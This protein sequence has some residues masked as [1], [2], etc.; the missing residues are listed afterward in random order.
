MLVV[1]IL[2]PFL[3]WLAQG[4]DSNACEANNPSVKGI[5]LIQVGFRNVRQSKIVFCPEFFQTECGFTDTQLADKST[6]EDLLVAAVQCCN[7]TQGGPPQSSYPEELCRVALTY[8]FDGHTGPVG[9]GNAQ[10]CNQLKTIADMDVAH[11]SDECALNKHFSEY[12]A[13]FDANPPES[14]E[15]SDFCP[16]F[17]RDNCGLSKRELAEKKTWEDLLETAVDCCSSTNE[18]G[19]YPKEICLDS[20]SIMFDGHHGPVG[21]GSAELCTELKMVA[22]V[23]KSHLRD[24]CRNNISFSAQCS[25]ILQAE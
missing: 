14:S 8:M 5:G 19:S 24:E 6:W 9:S 20:L 2:L 22:T 23:E 1:A 25:K 16:E 10:V 4:G 17:F 3:P 7:S 11:L 21:Q 12:C 18:A 15:R 13:F